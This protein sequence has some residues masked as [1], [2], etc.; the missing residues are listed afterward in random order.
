MSAAGPGLQY[1]IP[2]SNFS[3]ILYCMS[4]QVLLWLSGLSWLI[5]NLLA[6]RAL[7]SAAALPHRCLRFASVGSSPH[8]TLV[9]GT[10]PRTCRNPAS[11]FVLTHLRFVGALEFGDGSGVGKDQRAAWKCGNSGGESPGTGHHLVITSRNV[12][13]L[14]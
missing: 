1:C 10:R 14:L 3:Y 6:L 13:Y 7:T 8:T 5:A 4:I 12:S 11:Q 2:D 9:A